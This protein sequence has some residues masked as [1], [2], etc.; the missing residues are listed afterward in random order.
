[1]KKLFEVTGSLRRD[2]VWGRLPA[3]S[4]IFRERTWQRTQVAPQVLLLCRKWHLKQPLEHLF[5][6]TG[7]NLVHGFGAVDCGQTAMN[8][9]S[10]RRIAKTGE[11]GKP[12]T[13]ATERL[14]IIGGQIEQYL[15]LSFEMLKHEKCPSLIPVPSSELSRQ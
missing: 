10:R 4:G 1:V 5:V 3:A 2:P 7:H 8:E 6:A 13:R 14:E 15:L 9:L 12:L 11:V